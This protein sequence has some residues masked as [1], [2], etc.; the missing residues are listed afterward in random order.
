MAQLLTQFDSNQ[1]RKNRSAI[2]E[3]E[4]YKPRR[5]EGDEYPGVGWWRF[6]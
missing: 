3:S 6:C 4:S 5:R 2:Y 1:R